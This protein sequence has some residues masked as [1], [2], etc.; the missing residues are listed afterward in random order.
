MEK[1]QFIEYLNSEDGQGLISEQGFSKLSKESVSSFL[2]GTEEGKALQFSI[3]DKTHNNYMKKL[4]EKGS[5]VYDG[6][7]LKS[8]REQWRQEDNP[9]LTPDQVE[10]RELKNRLDKKE[11][12]EKATNNYKAAKKLNENIGLPS[13]VLDAYLERRSMDDLETTSKDLEGFG[14]IYKDAIDSKVESIVKERMGSS[15]KPTGGTGE[16]NALMEE[17][18]QAL[19]SGNTMEALRI[20]RQMNT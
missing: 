14:K 13:N 16:P 19:K 12:D 2:E 7:A 3:G 4:E 17:Y 5:K 10:I 8:L 15:Y 6:E 11:K 18:K 20:K 9:A 1:E